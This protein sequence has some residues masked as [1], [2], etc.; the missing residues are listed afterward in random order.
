MV[1]Y[2]ENMTEFPTNYTTTDKR[3]SRPIIPV[4]MQKPDGTWS[5]PIKF[6]FDTGASSP[7]DVPLQLLS[8]FGGQVATSARKAQPGKIIIPGFNNDQVIDI[9]IMVQDKAHY[10]LFRTQSTRYPLI[11]VYDLMPYMSIQYELSKTT[12]TPKSEGIPDVTGNAIMMPP[13]KQRTG[14]PTSA[15]YWTKGTMI[16]SKTYGD[17]WFNVCTGDYRFIIPRS[18]CDAAEFKITSDGISGNGESNA[19]GTFRWDETAPTKL[20]LSSIT[21]TARDDDGDFAR[22]GDPRCLMGGIN[23]LNK[24]RIVIWDDRMA[25]VPLGAVTPTPTPTPPDNPPLVE[26]ADRGD[27]RTGYDTDVSKWTAVNMRDYPER[28]KIIDKNLK[29]VRVDFQSLEN[30][31]LWLNWK[32][33]TIGLG[34]L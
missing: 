4:K 30:A 26:P 27:P 3:S 21:V 20:T 11:R 16:G 19:T 32:R 33:A 1:I 34:P 17:V 15:H 8:A 10:D 22:G 25:F 31:Q 5:D 23:F 14:T 29:N 9:P 28:G 12:L 24:Y 6:N 2:I 18:Y 13:A 7:T